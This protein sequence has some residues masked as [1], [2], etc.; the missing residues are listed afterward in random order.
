MINQVASVT[1]GMNGA[2]HLTKVHKAVTAGA[3]D[4]DAPAMATDTTVD[5]HSFREGVNSDITVNLTVSVNH[6][7]RAAN[8]P[9][10]FFAHGTDKQYVA[11][12][13][14]SGLI[15]AAHQLQQRTATAC[16]VA[17]TRRVIGIA[18]AQLHRYREETLY[19]CERR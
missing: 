19:P 6:E 13:F 1:H 8:I 2:R 15:K 10:S 16:V 3:G 18:F 4:I 11:F 17:D 9:V 12:G 7:F 14:N 5:H